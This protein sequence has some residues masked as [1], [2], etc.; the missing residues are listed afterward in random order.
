MDDG[1]QNFVDADALLGAGQH[2]VARIEADDGFNLL[3]DTL[4][5]GRRQIDL[6]DHRNDFQVVVQRQIRIGQRL[7]LHALRRVHHQQRALA[8]LQAARNFVGEIDVAGRIDQVQLVHLAIV[9]AIVQAHG[10]RLDGDAALALQVHGIEHLL[11][12]FALRQA[13]R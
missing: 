13:R 4:G 9:G 12:H 6:V 7:R 1:F 10:V 8:R 11:H 2:R 5:L 3:A